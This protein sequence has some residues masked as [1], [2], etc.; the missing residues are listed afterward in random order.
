MKRGKAC[1]QPKMRRNLLACLWNDCAI[2][3]ESSMLGIASSCSICVWCPTCPF[4]PMSAR[5]TAASAH[6]HDLLHFSVYFSSDLSC[7]LVVV[8]PAML[9]SH[10]TACICCGELAAL[11]PGAQPGPHAF[12][13]VHGYCADMH[14]ATEQSGASETCPQGSHVCTWQLQGSG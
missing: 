9:L 2:M 5:L 12:M 6:Q 11:R 13:H 3:L 4:S 7:I 14:N 8:L 10:A 1:L